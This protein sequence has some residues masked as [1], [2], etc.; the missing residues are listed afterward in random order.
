ME[1]EPF[2]VVPGSDR[3]EFDFTGFSQHPLS[4]DPAEFKGVPLP[5]I[6]NAIMKMMSEIAPNVS[7]TEDDMELAATVVAQANGDATE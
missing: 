6:T 3:L 2:D 1:E 4:L 5:A 7:F